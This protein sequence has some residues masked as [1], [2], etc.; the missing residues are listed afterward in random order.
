MLPDYKIPYGNHKL[1][2]KDIKKV[3][4]ILTSKYLT[5]GPQVDIFEKKINEFVGVKF[6]VATNSATSAL[7]I[8]CLLLRSYSISTFV[9]CVRGLDTNSITITVYLDW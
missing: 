4:K 3:N 9:A 6:S 5:Q 8:A 1:D 2:K 7:H